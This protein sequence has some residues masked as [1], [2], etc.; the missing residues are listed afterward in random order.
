MTQE[1]FW[2]NFNLGREV[3]LSGNL[4]YDGLLILEQM[5]NFGNE[6]E[7]FE[8]LYLISVGFERL[9]KANV[10]LIE[11][12][13]EIDQQ[14]FEKTLITHNHSDL[15]NRI[16]NKHKLNFGKVHNAFIHILSK[17]YKSCRYD[18]FTLHDAYNCDKEKH[19]FL[20]FLQ[21]HFEIEPC[22][23][24]VTF[25]NKQIKK[26]FGNLIKK[27]VTQLYQIIRDE[28]SRLCL[29]TYEIRVNS[30]A[31]K[32]FHRQDFTF[33]KERILQREILVYLLQNNKQSKFKEHIKE[34]LP[35]LKFEDG[36][37]RYCKPLM[38][39]KKSLEF[40]GELDFLYEEIENVK[41]RIED[42]DIIGED[43]L[44]EE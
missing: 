32:I 5:D 38:D 27:I 44:E 4:I 22:Q 13:N 36:E 37:N 6:D 24:F 14:E 43:Y 28:S 29:Y 21:K 2:K 1:R 12:N 35:P 39:V 3:Q 8:F 17:F 33:E 42:I 16:K 20:D 18:R 7:I 9:M 34:H 31:E 25:N 41:E 10:I 19:L 40:I 23:Y 11:H 30:K 15:I 26:L